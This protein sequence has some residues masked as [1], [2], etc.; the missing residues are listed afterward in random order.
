MAYERRR[1]STESDKS[2]TSTNHSTESNPTYNTISPHIVHP[3]I[4]TDKKLSITTTKESSHIIKRCSVMSSP[5]EELLART[6]N[7]FVDL[8]PYFQCSSLPSHWRKNKSLR[9]ILR[10]KRHIDIKTN[11]RVILFAGNDYNPCATLKNNVSWFR[12]GQAEFN[13]LRFLGASGRGKKFTLTIVIETTPPQ[14]CTYRRAIK[15]TVDGPRKKR[16]LKAKSDANEIQADESNFDGESD[17][18]TNITNNSMITESK[19][20]ISQ[21]SSGL[22]LLAAAAEQKRKDEEDI[23]NNR[24]FQSAPME[25]THSSKLSDTSSPI[26][27]CLSPSSLASQFSQSIGISRTSLDDLNSRL[28]HHV[29]L[30]NQNLAKTATVPLMSSSPTTNLIFT[31]TQTPNHFDFFHHHQQQQRHDQQTIVETPNNTSPTNTTTKHVLCR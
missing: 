23:P 11:T 7:T 3:T 8:N 15:I 1:L 22:L 19:P 26:T 13:D 25:I 29:F 18:E 27:S 21:G 28:S 20:F 16:E 6:K 30:Q 24:P 12:G 5:A 31:L 9:F 14:Q 2:S 17:N 10:T 4:P